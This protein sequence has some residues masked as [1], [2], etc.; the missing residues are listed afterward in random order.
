MNRKKIISIATILTLAMT[1][2]GCV[3]KYFYGDKNKEKRVEDKKII[4][5][6]PNETSNVEC[7]D[8]IKPEKNNCNRGIISGKNP[9]TTITQGETHTL[10]SIR[11]KTIHI[12]KTPKGYNFPE[13][14]GKV[15]LLEMF[16]KDCPHCLN[17]IHSIKKIRN[18]YKGKLEVIAIQSQDRM[19][20]F[21][22]RNY[23]NKYG[24]KYPIIE[25]EDAVNLQR[26]VQETFKWI[27]ILPYTLII[28]NGIV[29]YIHAG[30]VPYEKL[31]KDI[32]ELFQ[33]K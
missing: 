23:I 22:A 1:N 18:R 3:Q 10:K 33:A 9:N 26:D 15:I 21:T 29:G 12:I 5:T 31:Q 8:E 14:K 25:G 27:G 6:L 24:I 2:T 28:K 4:Q 20:K 30:E 7:I 16:G 19:S 17:Q 32:K 11:G 13:Y